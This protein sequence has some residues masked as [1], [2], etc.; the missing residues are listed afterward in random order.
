MLQVIM[1]VFLLLCFSV[2]HAMDSGGSKVN[3]ASKHTKREVKLPYLRPNDRYKQSKKRRE[4]TVI[5]KD[6]HCIWGT[7][8]KDPLR[9]YRNVQNARSSSVISLEA[10]FYKCYSQ[11]ATKRF[12]AS[13]L[14]LSGSF[15]PPIKKKH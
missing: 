10:S 2:T 6:D 1:A 7:V 4:G 5:K 15:L 14:S 12:V 13:R 11:G 9:N 3:H 8:R